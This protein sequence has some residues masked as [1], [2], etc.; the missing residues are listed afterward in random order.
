M[1]NARRVEHGHQGG[2]AEGVGAVVLVGGFLNGDAAVQPAAVGLVVLLGVVGVAGVRVVAAHHEGAGNGAAVLLLRLAEGGVHAHEHVFEEGG[3]GALLGVAADLL[4]VEARIDVYLVFICAA[5]KKTLERGVGAG[6]VVELRRADELAGGP[7]NPRRLAVIDEEVAREHIRGAHAKVVG[8][9]LVEGA[10]GKLACREERHE[11]FRAVELKPAVHLAVEVDGHA[12]NKRH[13]AARVVEAARHTRALADEHATG[14]AER[15][16]EPGVVDHAAV[17]LDVEPQVIGR[18]LELGH[19]LDLEDRRVAVSGSYLEVV[20]VELLA[21]LERDD[22]RAVAGHVVA[23]AGPDVPGIA[24]RKA[25]E[26]RR[27]EPQGKLGRGMEHGGAR[28]DEVAER[29][30]VV[31]GR[32]RGCLDPEIGFSNATRV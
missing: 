18:S 30:G 2:A 4:V 10:G 22:A 23:P 13:V 31:S 28:V 7:P 26:A 25:R 8:N 15:A 1:R 20:V 3:H 17:G 16:V 29:A 21:D 14:D 6:K 12:G 19:G 11:V 9:H 32:H 24:L 27:L 5:G